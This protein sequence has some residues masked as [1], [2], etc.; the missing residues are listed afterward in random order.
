MKILFHFTIFTF[1]TPS[2]VYAEGHKAFPPKND[3]EKCLLKF[4][5]A[6]L[7]INVNACSH[8]KENTVALPLEVGKLIQKKAQC[9]TDQVKVLAAETTAGYTEQYK[10]CKARF[11][12]EVGQ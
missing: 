4:N 9:I 6:D 11:P 8:Q 5:G 10:T 12:K 7:N 2:G 3:F 1:L